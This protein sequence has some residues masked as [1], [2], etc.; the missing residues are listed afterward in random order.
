MGNTYADVKAKFVGRMNRRDMTD[1]LADGFLQDAIKRIQRTMRIPCMEKTIIVTVDATYTT[2]GGIF[3]P[4]DFIKIRSMSY[5]DIE[6]PRREDESLV[7]PM[8]QNVGIPTMYTRRGGLWVFAPT[9]DGPYLVNG[10]LTNNFIRINYWAEF[11]PMIAPTDETVLTDIA[12]D[13]MTYAALSY[14][15]DHFTDK[16]GDKYE[17]RYLQ[18]KD[19]IENQADEDETAGAAVQPALCYDDDLEGTW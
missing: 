2:N 16:R 12:D 4:S 14:A 17:A 3:I 9:P 1:A 5:N 18:I 11:D 8:L 6:F 10:V 19:D 7:V 13:L 15:C